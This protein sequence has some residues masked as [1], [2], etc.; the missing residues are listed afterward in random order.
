M[1][2]T[3]KQNK[4]RPTAKKSARTCATCAMAPI[5]IFVDKPRKNFQG[6]RVERVGLHAMRSSYVGCVSA[7]RIRRSTVH[8]GQCQSHLDKEDTTA[9]PLNLVPQQLRARVDGKFRFCQERIPS[10]CCC[11]THCSAH[12]LK[13]FEFSMWFLLSDVTSVTDH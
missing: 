11:V 7:P 5:V 6:F 8:H 1:I 9:A 4:L 2:K 10:T 3:N 12:L 13:M